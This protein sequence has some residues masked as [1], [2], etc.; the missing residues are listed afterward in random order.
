VVNSKTW[1]TC[2]VPFDMVSFLTNR[3]V[4]NLRKARLFAVALCRMYWRRL[5]VAECRWLVETVE[6]YVEGEMG[7][8][9]VCLARERA[10]EAYEQRFGTKPPT[11]S[12]SRLA[13]LAATLRCS[14]QNAREVFST[15]VQLFPPL[16]FIRTEDARTCELVRCVCGNPFSKVKFAPAWR[17]SDAVALAQSMYDSRNFGA[18]PILADALQDAGCDNSDVLNHCR[19][20]NQVHVRGCWVCDLV[21]GK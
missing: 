8:A 2:N 4:P 11:G 20:A 10:H 3:R 9:D 21:L 15:Y 14:A 6:E 19:D 5:P 7:W 1:A 18:M 17:T 12:P 13:L 16:S